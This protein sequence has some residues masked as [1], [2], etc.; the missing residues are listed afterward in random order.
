[1]NL[2]LFFGGRLLLFRRSRGVFGTY[3]RL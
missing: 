1:M 3:A 2:D